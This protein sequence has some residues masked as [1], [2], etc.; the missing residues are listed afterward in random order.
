MQKMRQVGLDTHPAGEF[1]HVASIEDDPVHVEE[2]EGLPWTGRP[3]ESVG[4]GLHVGVRPPGLP[5]V[6]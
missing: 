5:G 1:D 4:L 6:D 2:G 3:A